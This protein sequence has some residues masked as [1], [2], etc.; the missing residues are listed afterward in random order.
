MSDCS[1]LTKNMLQVCTY[2]QSF[3]YGTA[4]KTVRAV[5]VV[6]YSQRIANQFMGYVNQI[7]PNKRQDLRRW[8]T[9]GCPLIEIKTENMDESDPSLDQEEKSS[10]RVYYIHKK[11]KVMI[12]ILRILNHYFFVLIFH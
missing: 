8:D 4:T 2:H 3:Q 7:R 11:V 9:D 10:G 12:L 1:P 5:P 6:H